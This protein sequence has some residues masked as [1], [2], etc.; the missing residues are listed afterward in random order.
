MMN[1]DGEGM[2]QARKFFRN[3]L[4]QIG[5]IEPTEDEREMMIKQAQANQQPDA[6]EQLLLSAAAEAQAKAQKAQ[7]RCY[8]EGKN[9]DPLLLARVEVKEDSIHAVKG[10]V[11]AADQ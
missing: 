9:Q 6:N 11:E 10:M 4:L 3:K 5:A 8:E 1:L 2:I 7:A